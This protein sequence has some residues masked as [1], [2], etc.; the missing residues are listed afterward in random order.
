MRIVN[1]RL[2]IVKTVDNS[3]DNATSNVTSAATCRLNI[4]IK[5]HFAHFLP[6]TTKY[7]KPIITMIRAIAQ[8]SRA[9][10]TRIVSKMQSTTNIA[11][12]LLRALRAAESN[13]VMLIELKK[14][15]V[16]AV[17]PPPIKS[18]K[19]VG[20]AALSDP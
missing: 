7:I 6:F 18:Q 8:A 14:T 16:I 10:I 4:P 19:S 17:S 12:S 9:I 11:T 13:V 5:I 15:D 2:P 1:I 3:E 20:Q